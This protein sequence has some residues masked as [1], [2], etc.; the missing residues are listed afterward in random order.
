[1]AKK[2]NREALIETIMK[3][4]YGTDDP[5]YDRSNRAFLETLSISE[6]SK[7]AD[8]DYDEEEFDGEVTD[9]DFDDDL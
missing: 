6:L 7:L 8:E 1:M 9:F 4:K 3:N 5:K 2:S